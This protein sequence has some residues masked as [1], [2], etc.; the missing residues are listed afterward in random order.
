VSLDRENLSL[1][2]MTKQVMIVPTPS[3]PVVTQGGLALSDSE[4]AE[5]LADSLE[6]QFSR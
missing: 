4:T 2:K 6:A 5:A 3:P 1:F